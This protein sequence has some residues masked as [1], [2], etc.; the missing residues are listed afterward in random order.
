MRSEPRRAEIHAAEAPCGRNE[1]KRVRA[2]PFERVHVPATQAGT[3]A[4]IKHAESIT[5]SGLSLRLCRQ[6]LSRIM[7]RVRSSFAFSTSEARNPNLA[8]AQCLAPK[9]EAFICHRLNT[10]LRQPEHGNLA[11]EAITRN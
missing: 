3:T 6:K 1:M 2:F 4:S 5:L 7:M 9:L 8:G 11:T 10:I